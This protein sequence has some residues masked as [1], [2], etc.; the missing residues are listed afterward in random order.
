[1]RRVADIYQSDAFAAVLAAAESKD[2][3]GRDFLTCLAVAYQVFC[4]M[5]WEAPV[6]ER[7]FDHTVQ[8]AYGVAAGTSR[9]LGLS[10]EQAANALAIVGASAQGL[11]IT[12]AEYL[13]QW[14]GL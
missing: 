9:A 8:L 12:R 6:Q 7:G 4:R 5:L 10:R 11:V 3:A 2:L 14:K 13:S 1:M